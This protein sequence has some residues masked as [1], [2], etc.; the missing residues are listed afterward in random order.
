MIATYFFVVY[1]EGKDWKNDEF[2][3][4][5]ERVQPLVDKI[6]QGISTIMITNISQW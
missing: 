1:D 3:K 5:L 4:T 6:I 2:T